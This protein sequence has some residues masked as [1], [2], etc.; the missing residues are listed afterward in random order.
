MMTFG[1]KVKKLREDAQLSQSALGRR[2]GICQ[3]CIAKWENG[4]SSLP[5]LRSLLMLAKVFNLSL[6]EFDN[7][8]LPVDRR[9]GRSRRAVN[10]RPSKEAQK[11]G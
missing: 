10:K 2:M 11:I 1:D 6:S 7:V 5:T 3:V 9:N 8:R 4:E